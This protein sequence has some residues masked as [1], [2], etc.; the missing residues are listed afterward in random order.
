MMGKIDK[1]HIS[2]MGADIWKQVSRVYPYDHVLI[3]FKTPRI[4]Y[5]QTILS[6]F[7][8]GQVELFVHDFT[9]NEAMENNQ[10]ILFSKNHAKKILELVERE[11]HN[12]FHI[13]CVCGAGISRSSATAAALGKILYNDDTFIFDNP[14]YIP[15]SHVYSTILRT[16]FER[17]IPLLKPF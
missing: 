6:P 5:R 8:R 4:N 15:N 17:D 16:N 11:K 2:V 10:I 1:I 7:C 9:P 12:I 13:I 3:R 14:R